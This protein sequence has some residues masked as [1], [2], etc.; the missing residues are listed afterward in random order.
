MMKLAFTGHRP[1][2]LPFGDNEDAE[3]CRALKKLL[4]EEIVKRID[5]GY[6]TFYCGAAKGADI[7]CGELVL[8]AQ[9]KLVIPIQLICVVPFKDQAKDWNDSWKLRYNSLLEKSSQILRLSDHYYRGCYYARDRYIV[10]HSD[11][12][13]AVYSGKRGGT[14]Y[15]VQYACGKAKEVVIF[16]PFAL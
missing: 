10:D 16:N 2:G 7:I 14:S 6:D 9:E 11:A 1:E 8:M 5:T 12:L 15:T 4:W 13:I 3:S